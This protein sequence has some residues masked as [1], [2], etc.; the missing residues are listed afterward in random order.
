MLDWKVKAVAI[1]FN[2]IRNWPKPNPQPIASARR[3]ERARNSSSHKPASAIGSSGHQPVGW[4][5]KA[6]MAPSRRA[7]NWLHAL[8]SLRGAR[9]RSN[10]ERE[11]AYLKT[12]LLAAFRKKR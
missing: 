3:S 4:K 10:A 7:R 8:T 5:A 9:R 6:E 12:S 11:R 1:Q 2:A